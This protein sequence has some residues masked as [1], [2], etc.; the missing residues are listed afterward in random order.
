MTYLNR[1]LDKLTCSHEWDEVF[2]NKWSGDGTVVIVI[3]KCKKCG[4]FKKF[5]FSE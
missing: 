3:Y 5:R 2:R 1:I 4:K